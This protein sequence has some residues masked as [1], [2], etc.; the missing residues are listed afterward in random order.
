M[1]AVVDP[2]VDLIVPIVYPL[3]NV[4]EVNITVFSQF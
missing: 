3:L 1:A 4:P 2:R